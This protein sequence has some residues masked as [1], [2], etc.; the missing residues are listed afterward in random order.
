MNIIIASLIKFTFVI[1]ILFSNST[2]ANNIVLNK[3][4]TKLDSRYQYTY[5][6]MTLIIEATPDFGPSEVETSNFYMTRDRALIE[7]KSGKL[8]NVMAEAPKPEWDESLLVIPIPI[9]KGIQGL[10]VFIIESENNILMQSINTLEA[11]KNLPTG[12]GSHWSTNVAMETAGFDV[13]TGSNYNGLFGMLYKDRFTTFG[14]G[15]NEAYKEVGVWQK[16]Y[17]NLMVDK[18][19]L[20][21]IPLATYFYVSPKTPKIAKRIKVGLLRLIE[22]GSFDHFFYRRHCKDILKAQINK[23]KIFHIP[24]SL[25]S[26]KRMLSLVD[27]DYLIDIKSDFFEICQQYQ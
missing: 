11:L 12:S 7:L 19:V 6:L 9:R 5:N 18:H 10:R 21:H 13:I 4:Q 3:Q 8:I 24:N 20:L 26:H 2:F 22:N 15:I 25:V 17:P 16:Q 1:A 27:D 14:R 23:R